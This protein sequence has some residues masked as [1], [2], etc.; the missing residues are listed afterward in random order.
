MKKLLLVAFI[1]LVCC[2]SGFTQELNHPKSIQ[3]PVYFDVSPPLRDLANLQPLKA[4]QTWKDGVVKN[5]FNFN[6]PKDAT[7]NSDYSDNQIQRMFGPLTVDT[8]IENFEGLGGNSVI[9]PD[10]DGDVGPNHYF[11]VV[12]CMYAIFNKSGAKVLGPYASSSVWAGMPNNVNSG[13]AV[14]VY[15]EMANRWF[16]SQFSLPTF[17]NGPFYQMVAVSQTPDPTGS[18]YRFQYKFDDMPDYPKFGVWPDGYYMSCNRFSSGSTGWMGT[19]AAAFDRTAMLSGD[20]NA[21]MVYFTTS[22][23]NEASSLLPSDC[24]GTFPPVG[25]PNYFTYINEGSPQH[26]GILEFSVNWVVPSLSTFGNL[27]SLPVSAFNPA[28]TGIPQLGTSETLSTLGDRLMFR[29]Q[30]R[31]FSNRWSMVLNH[32]VNAT[33]NQAGVRWYELQKTTGAW[34]IF[35]QSTYAPADGKSRWMGSIAMDTAGNIALGYSISGPTMYPSIRYTGRMHNDAINTMTINERGIINGTGAQTSNTHR[36][37]DYSSMRVDPQFPTTFWY[38]TEYYS[39]TGNSNWQTRIGSFTFQTQLATY[40]TVAPIY[41]CQGDSVSL[42]A[43]AYGGS[44]NY[45]YQWSSIPSGFT[46]TLK[47]PKTLPLV[48]TKYVAVIHDGAQ[49]RY[50]TTSLVSVIPPPSGFAGNDTTICSYHGSIDLFGQASSY[51][52]IGWGTTGKG[53]F[54]STT[55]LNTTY[56]FAPQDYTKD[57]I[58][59]VL[60][61]LPLS[62]CKQMFISTMHV[63]LDPCNGIDE[64]NSKTCD[65][66]V[67]PN[68]ASGSTV[69]TITNLDKKPVTLSIINTNGQTVYSELINPSTSVFT[70]TIDLGPYS[71]G[72][73]FIQ[74]RTDTRVIMKK[75][76][77]Q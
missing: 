6:H 18:W 59:I 36:W 9:P 37:G 28:Y 4:D 42:N 33:S 12:N 75:L 57:S 48:N 25:T 53:H 60:M 74:A 8:T 14:V 73:Y 69:V 56:Y 15:D 41:V 67:Q 29:Q 2:F 17:P 32:S 13:D 47:S 7:P 45:T 58:D 19:G 55:A 62:P 1:S 64:E 21:Q 27:L 26:L 65:L 43:V 40:A 16:F 24:D 5:F 44:G 54:S 68:P 35:Q 3:K 46:S 72:I 76:V 70:K 34:S 52:V 11:Q 61:V 31:K 49:I 23:Y 39:Y 71:S 10:T 20:P 22:Y 30:F 77:I 63:K 51:R 50:D 66:T 38:T